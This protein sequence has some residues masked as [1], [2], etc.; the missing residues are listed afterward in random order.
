MALAHIFRFYTLGMTTASISSYLCFQNFLTASRYKMDEVI[1]EWHAWQ[2]WA[3]LE[4]EMGNLE[5][6]RRLLGRASKLDPHHV[7]VWQVHP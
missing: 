7:P 1:N 5:I 6:A 2:A 3:L 4:E